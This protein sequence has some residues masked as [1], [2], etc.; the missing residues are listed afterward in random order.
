M[1]PPIHN[2]G[3]HDDQKFCVALQNCTQHDPV[4]SVTGKSLDE[5]SEAI[6]EG[7]LEGSESVEAATGHSPPLISVSPMPGS[8]LING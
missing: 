6:D 1:K 2:E 8:I 7:P 3:P 4:I 5:D